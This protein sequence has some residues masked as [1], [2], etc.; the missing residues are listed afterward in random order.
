MNTTLPQPKP[1]VVLKT[2]RKFV[3][4]SGWFAVTFPLAAVI[5]VTAMYAKNLNFDVRKGASSG[6]QICPEGQR[7][8]NGSC[9]V[10]NYYGLNA[11]GA[12]ICGQG[13]Y[14]VL[15][16]MLPDGEKLF[17]S[18]Y[19]MPLSETGE[20][21]KRSLDAHLYNVSD[22]FSTGDVI[23][24][25]HEGS[26]EWYRWDRENV[27]LVL[28]HEGIAGRKYTHD[29][30][31]WFKR[32]MRV[33]DVVKGL[34]DGNQYVEYDSNTCQSEVR[35]SDFP[36]EHEL[37]EHLSSYDA[38]GDL[39]VVNDVLV[40]ENR[41]SS[42]GALKYEEFYFSKEHGWFQHLKIDNAT[43][44]TERE[45]A[46]N[47]VGKR[48]DM[49]F[50]LFTTCSVGP[51][52]KSSEFTGQTNINGA[53]IYLGKPKTRVL[54]TFRNT[55]TKDWKP[56]EVTLVPTAKM[57]ESRWD[58]VKADLNK[59]VRPGQ[60]FEFKADIPTPSL[61]GEYFIEFRVSS[62]QGGVFGGKSNL[63]KVIVK[64]QESNQQDDSNND[65]SD[66]NTD[67]NSGSTPPQTGS[68]QGNSKT[69][70]SPLPTS[71]SQISNNKPTSNPKSTAGNS[72]SRARQEVADNS[73]FTYENATLSKSSA[74]GSDLLLPRL[75]R[76]FIS[77][78]SGFVRSVVGS[79]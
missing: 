73:I 28:N 25:K 36:Y 50:P 66:S 14:D 6:Y 21:V 18:K 11:I 34:D 56:G 9:V 68:S 17:N 62:N 42:E 49:T 26:F 51:N 75:V 38:G 76:N 40:M 45:R 60:T 23:F 1:R 35:R 4:H 44:E 70:T 39:G 71:T 58:F 13:E 57:K 31:V 77:T 20:R 16:Y 19:S 10:E 54:V 53:Q 63:M 32:C 15:D 52:F 69:G 79:E 43:G 65:E 24:A 27:Y 7:L 30:G 59:I 29:P 72:A 2:V 78:V 55:G 3:K 37:R 8:E 67:S 46:A 5:L 12:N 33:G 22:D 61:V 64:P 48:H 74:A 41:R 47:Q